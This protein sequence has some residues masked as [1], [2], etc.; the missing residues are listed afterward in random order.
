MTSDDF[1][2]K[3]SAL[4]PAVQASIRAAFATVMAE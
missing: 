3:F 4:D 1:A 2:A